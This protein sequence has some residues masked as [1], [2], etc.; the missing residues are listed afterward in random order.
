MISHELADFVYDDNDDDVENMRLCVCVY[1]WMLRM[2]CFR[3]L[4]IPRNFFVGG[5]FM[6]YFS[7][8]IHAYVASLCVVYLFSESSSRHTHTHIPTHEILKMS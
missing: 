3:S 2:Q 7:T 1:V 6:N 4:D 8:F 5:M